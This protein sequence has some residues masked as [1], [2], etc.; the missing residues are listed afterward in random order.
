MSKIT[1]GS[2][3]LHQYTPSGADLEA[4]IRLNKLS[5][6]TVTNVQDDQVLVY[7][8]N[9]LPSPQWVNVSLSDIVT[10][11]GNISVVNSTLTTTDS[12]IDF[13]ADVRFLQDFEVV[14]AGPPVINSDSSITLTAVTDIILNAA[15][16]QLNGNFEVDGGTY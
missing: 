16:I 5:D 8:G 2:G 15:D 11:I 6:V 12:S 7:D 10:D 13:D 4:E 14:G 3:T 1:L 9:L